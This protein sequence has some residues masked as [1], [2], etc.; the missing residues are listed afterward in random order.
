MRWL[1]YFIVQDAKKMR[2]EAYSKRGEL[3]ER[4]VLRAALRTSEGP[5]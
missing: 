3:S 1:A 5:R 2:L 4:L